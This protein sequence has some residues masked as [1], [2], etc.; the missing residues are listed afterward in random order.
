M[1]Y[2][3]VLF[4]LDGTLLDTLGDIADSANAVLAES[5]LPTHDTDDYRHFIG[6]GIEILMKRALP[7]SRRDEMTVNS[8]REAFRRIYSHQWNVHSKPYDGIVSLLDTLTRRH[9]KLAVLSNKPDDFT[10]KCV[11]EFFPGIPFGMVLGH[12][13]GHAPKPDP[14]G[15]NRIAEAIGV[16]ADRILFVGDSAVDMKTAANA[17]MHPVGALWGFRS[18]EELR[19]NGAEALVAHPSD[20]MALLTA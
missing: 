3:A 9:L 10:K 18:L 2:Q 8:C 7:E 20:M 17:G 13:P 1:N 5:D 15:A 16:S 4:D 11:Q 14:A 19:D 6:N 12:R